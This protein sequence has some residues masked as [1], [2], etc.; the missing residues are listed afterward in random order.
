MAQSLYIHPHRCPGGQLRIVVLLDDALAGITRRDDPSVV[1]AAWMTPNPD[2]F[3]RRLL[4]RLLEYPNND[5]L[6]VT[7]QPSLPE[8]LTSNV[9]YAPATQWTSAHGRVD[10]RERDRFLERWGLTALQRAAILAPG[11]PWTQLAQRL[12]H[13]EWTTPDHQLQLVL[14]HRPRLGNV[15]RGVPTAVIPRARGSLYFASS[16]QGTLSPRQQEWRVAVAQ[17]QL[18]AVSDETLQWML[19]HRVQ[20][21]HDSIPGVPAIADDEAV[22]VDMRC[23]WLVKTT[24]A[25]VER[26]LGGTD[27]LTDAAARLS[28][29]PRDKLRLLPVGPQ[30]QLPAQMA[31]A[32]SLYDE[33]WLQ[34]WALV[35][36]P[37]DLGHVRRVIDQA[38]DTLGRGV[39]DGVLN[40]LAAQVGV[41][42]RLAAAPTDQQVQ[43]HVRQCVAIAL[44]IRG[45]STQHSPWGGE[46]DLNMLVATL[47][48]AVDGEIV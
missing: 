26:A 19:A 36:Q 10:P 44:A 43:D 7:L 13:L 20:S 5:T 38:V 35:G 12:G 33:G 40:L 3:D 25:D 41:P 1:F 15:A 2:I 45:V 42:S 16:P 32:V 27:A 24:R 22:V 31:P 34:W 21:Q 6:P 46:A 4:A 18:E 39:I 37:V 9:L 14:I 30:A 17:G 29:E 23:H 11:R 8:I 28:L 48:R 47:R